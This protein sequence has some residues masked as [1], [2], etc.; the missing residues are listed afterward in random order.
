MAGG[1]STAGIIPLNPTLIFGNYLK[2]TMIGECTTSDNSGTW[3]T[4][5]IGP[6]VSTGGYDWWKFEK[7]EQLLSFSSSSV[8]SQ[9]LRPFY[10]ARA[11]ASRQCVRAA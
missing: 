1:T 6:F 9:T 8:Q 3:R 7:W 10:P 5:R 11:P 4:A 2:P